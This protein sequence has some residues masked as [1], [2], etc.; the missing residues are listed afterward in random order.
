MR[1]LR[2]AAVQLRSG[3]EPAANRAAAIPLLREAAAAGARLIAT[4]EC[5]TLLDRDKARMLTNVA[6]EKD[7]PEIGAWGRLAQELGVWLLLGSGSVAAGNG[8][9]FNRSFLF[10]DTGK[11]AARYDKIN[12]FDVE[13]GGGE[14]Y[15]ESA[16]F[17]GGAK[18]VL[19][20]GPMGA[21]IGL[22]IC[23]DLRFAPLY[24]AYAQAGAEIITVPAA[25]TVP[26][27]QAHWETLLRA[28]AIESLC[29][30]IAPAQG[31]VHEDGRSTYGHSMIIDPWGKVLAQ[32]DH[33]A[34]G[35]IVADLD[36]D[37][38][39]AARGKIPSWRGGRE[40]TGP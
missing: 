26:T 31:G 17:E 34:P 15:R 12:L 13:L 38:V 36:L 28:R 37:A 27:G 19:A 20:E 40:F 10:S 21:K 39:G 11:I 29:Y 6:P 3:V 22:S 4:P 8:K 1:K 7:D 24:N 18:A 23:Y 30:V 25:F 16:T 2:V 14:S 35:F 32:L 9:V 5:T 33:D